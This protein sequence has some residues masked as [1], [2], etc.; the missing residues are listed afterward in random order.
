M[1]KNV[2]G[3]SMTPCCMEP[4]TGYFRDGFCRTDQRDAETH[5]ICAVV[6]QDFLEYSLSKGNDLITPIPYWNFLRLQP[7]DRNGVCLFLGGCK[8]RKQENRCQSF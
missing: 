7:G 3:D 1:G 8:R 5:V 2:F 4:L 6:S